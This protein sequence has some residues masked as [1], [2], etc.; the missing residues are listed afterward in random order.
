MHM[1]LEPLRPA[2]LRHLHPSNAAGLLAFGGVALT[3][4]IG[5]ALAMRTQP[6]VWILGQL[7]LALA[8]VQWFVL[9]HECGHDTLFRSRRPHAIAAHAAAFFSIV[10][11]ACWTRVHGRHHR[12]TGWQD[13]DPT[14][15]SRSCR[16]NA[17][18]SSARS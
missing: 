10:R 7:I 12:W 5:V 14:E 3:T 1:N 9:L 17:A 6:V 4:A 18:G 2:D 11:Y 16:G 15:L 13:M 8:F